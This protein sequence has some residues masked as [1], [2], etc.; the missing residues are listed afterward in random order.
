MAYW[1]RAFSNIIAKSFFTS[2]IPL[3]MFGLSWSHLLLTALPAW[4]Y[5]D[6]WTISYRQFL[7]YV[8][9]FIAETHV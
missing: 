9:S 6:M 2:C 7:T 4:P 1:D 8:K 3:P 5:V